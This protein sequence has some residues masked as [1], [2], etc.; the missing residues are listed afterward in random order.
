[1]RIEFC[2][3]STLGENVY[4]Y[5]AKRALIGTVNTKSGEI[6]YISGINNYIAK[7]KGDTDFSVC[8]NGKI[9]ILRGDAEEIIVYTVE[10]NSCEYIPLDFA[11][12]NFGN[13]AY[14]CAYRD[15]VYI[16]P[17]FGNTIIQIQKTN[18][19]KKIQ[20]RFIDK[21][22]LIC[23]HRIGEKVY[24]FYRNGKEVLEIS[25]S[26]FT[27]KEHLVS[28]E[29]KEIRTCAYQQNQIFLL[30]SYGTVYAY[31]LKEKNEIFIRNT[32]SNRKISSYHRIVCTGEAIILFPLAADD[33]VIIN[34]SDKEIRVYKE[35][36]EEFYYFPGRES[37][38]YYACSEDKQF[39][40]LLRCSNYMLKVNKETAEFN[41]VRIKCPSIKELFQLF[42]YYNK[43]VIQE[44]EVGLQKILSET[45][46]VDQESVEREPV[47]KRIWKEI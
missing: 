5:D 6:N 26:D 11:T 31:D 34:L 17:R 12:R 14:L 4:F 28:I 33:I 35:Y 18:K 29:M 24:L 39:Y 43:D 36:P 8:N 16:F 3:Y 37:R 21:G 41:W 1:M 32:W 9:Y 30:N 44:K 42:K 25:L 22:E 2:H 7:A 23:G 10:D 27:T 15:N 19:V 38:K 13:C 47:G 46:I 40:Y 20:C 45:W